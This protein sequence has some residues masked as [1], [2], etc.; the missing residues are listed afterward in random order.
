MTLRSPQPPANTRTQC[1]NGC[2]PVRQTKPTFYISIPP[3]APIPTD[4]FCSQRYP[5][6][7]HSYFSYKLNYGILQILDVFFSFQNPGERKKGTKGPFGQ[8]RDQKSLFN[9]RQKVCKLD[10]MKNPKPDLL[11]LEIRVDNTMVYFPLYSC[12]S[13]ALLASLFAFK[14]NITFILMEN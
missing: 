13:C 4:T 14:C 1:S 11:L 8:G 5:R 9:E 12:N 2:S 7:I 3:P 10:H 6:H